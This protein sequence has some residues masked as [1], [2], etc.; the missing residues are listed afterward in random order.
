MREM[1]RRGNAA[2]GVNEGVS[3]VHRSD[4][5]KIGGWK[6]T[7]KSLLKFCEISRFKSRNMLKTFSLSGGAVG[8]YFWYFSTRLTKRAKITNF[9]TSMPSY[10]SI[11][12]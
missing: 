2:L 4:I 11:H 1:K 12:L 6:F 7:A 9:C 3:N 10:V 8:Y 5:D